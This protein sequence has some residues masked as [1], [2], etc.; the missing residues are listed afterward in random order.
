MAFEDMLDHT[1]TIYHLSKDTENLGYGVEDEHKYSYPKY[2][3]EK[4]TDIPCHFGV[5]SGENKVS[6]TEP[7]NQYS[8]R[9]KLTLPLGTDIRV[10]DK[11]VSG[12]TGYTYIAEL[13][14][15][16]RGHHIIVYV[17]RE[18]TVKEAI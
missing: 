13:P 10:N 14:R 16:I 12:E 1:C 5:K 11:V 4:D 18:G 8:A 7:V 9:L 6:Q 17:H 2:A 3:E 15:T